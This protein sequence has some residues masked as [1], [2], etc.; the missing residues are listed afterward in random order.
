[1]SKAFKSFTCI[2]R[3]YF[4]G[5]FFTVDV[6]A[7]GRLE[8]FQSLIYGLKEKAKC[9]R[10]GAIAGLPRSGKSQGNTKIF[11]GQ[12]KVRVFCKRSGKILKV[13]KSQWKVR[14]LNFWPEKYHEKWLFL[15]KFTAVLVL[16]SGFQVSYHTPTIIYK[17]RW[18]TCT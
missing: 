8:K 13:C 16:N 2:R 3:F 17:I 15:V 10:K 4:R 1:M 9:K 18:D 7:L 6:I 14:E 12:V 5:V 11:Q